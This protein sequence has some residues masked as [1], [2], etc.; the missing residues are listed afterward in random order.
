M[1]IMDD[2]NKYYKN[3]LLG[4]LCGEYRGYWQSAHNDKEK[5]V[6]LALQQQCLP[7]LISYSYEGKGLSKEYILENFKDYI[8]GNYIGIN[9]DGV[10]GDY[11]SEL[12]VGFNGILTLCDDILCTMWTSIPYLNLPT[13]KATKIYCGCSSELHINCDG[14]NNVII[15]LFDD[16]VV[17]LEDFD[18][19]C[20]ANIYKYS[21]KCKV[22]YGKYCLS[23]RINEHQKELRL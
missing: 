19:T 21:D 23:K 14:F 6:R 11:K 4:N 22:N 17:S 12:Y 3:A 5:L 7:H 8:N 9:V 20:S 18:E 13:C 16:S 2:L 1:L 15:M 10:D